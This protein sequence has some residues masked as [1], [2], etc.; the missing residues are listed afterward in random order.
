MTKQM[1][2]VVIGSLK[3][4]LES[5][6][7]NCSRWNSVVLIIYFSEK[8]RLGIL[9]ESSA[10]QMIHMKC[11]VLFSLKKKKKKKKIKMLSAAVVVSILWVK[12]NG[13]AALLAIFL[14]YFRK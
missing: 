1:T 9:C 3:F 10:R 4:N 12:V 5:A 8:I 6:K 7:Q 2:I 11:H 13:V 14:L